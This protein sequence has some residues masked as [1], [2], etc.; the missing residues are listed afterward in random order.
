MKE[1]NC[2]GFRRT[3]RYIASCPQL[4]PHYTRQSFLRFTVVS[5]VNWPLF[6]GRHTVFWQ[7]LRHMQNDRNLAILPILPL[8][9][10]K[11]NKSV[12]TSTSVAVDPP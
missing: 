9:Y 12:V 4:K 5:T 2:Q 3:Q 1:Q 10:H 6:S 11:A 8:N 7:P